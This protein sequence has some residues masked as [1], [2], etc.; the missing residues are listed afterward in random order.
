MSD[1]PNECGASRERGVPFH[2]Y[3][4]PVISG[5]AMIVFLEKPRLY[6]TETRCFGFT[7][8]TRRSR[9]SHVSVEGPRFNYHTGP[10]KGPIVTSI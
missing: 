8:S 3:V 7:Q 1:N 4:S 2:I 5:I 6:R 10:R 9:G